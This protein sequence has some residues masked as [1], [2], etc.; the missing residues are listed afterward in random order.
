MNYG[1]ICTIE[2]YL[3]QTIKN[4]NNVKSKNKIIS[5]TIQNRVSAW[6]AASNDTLQAAKL[7]LNGKSSKN[8]NI[9][10]D[11][12]SDYVY[13]GGIAGLNFGA[14]QGCVNYDMV[15]HDIENPYAHVGGI[16]GF[17]DEYSYISGLNAGVVQGYGSTGGIVG[18]NYGSIDFCWNDD[19]VFYDYSEEDRWAGGIAGM[20]VGGILMRSANYGTVKYIGPIIVD[21]ILPGMGQLAGLRFV[22]GSVIA[23]NSLSGTLS[24]DKGNLQNYQSYYVS[25]GETGHNCYGCH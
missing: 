2:S 19:D 21:P 10:S 13:L 5:H 16:A 20:H 9:E 22:S 25:N 14:I 18:I 24:V 12:E 8:R 3:T 15:C 17:N 6:Q 7:V 1:E 11:I 4:S 23:N